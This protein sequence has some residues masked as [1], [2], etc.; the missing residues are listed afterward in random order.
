VLAGIVPTFV[1]VI[2]F[3]VAANAW[4]R[5]ALVPSA[6]VAA[7]FG[8]LAYFTLLA[9]I[10]AGGSAVGTPASVAV[11]AVTGFAAGF[12]ERYATDML[13]SAAKLIRK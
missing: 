11:F 5:S 9:G 4:W 6:L 8:S 12:S 7:I 10:L 1:L 2:L 13:D 3:G